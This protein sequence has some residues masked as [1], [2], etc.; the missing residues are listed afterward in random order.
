MNKAIVFHYLSK[1]MLVGSILFFLPACISLYYGENHAAATFSIVAAGIA[2]LSLPMSIITP[3]NKRM[4]AREGLVI[5]A[6]LWII[7]PVFGALPFYIS[8]EI[9]DFFDA[10]FESIS[11]FTTTGSTILTDIESLS[12][13]MIFWRS[14]THWVGGM[15][16][17]VLA[18]AI[19]PSTN[20]TMY[21]MKA[22]CPG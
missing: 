14:F 15:G 16:V 4:F 13:G 22:E 20:G 18:I 12:H 8:G 11:G 2:V 6:L 10:L 19:L 21:L 5:V 9:P 1:I 17:L 7:Y 3:K